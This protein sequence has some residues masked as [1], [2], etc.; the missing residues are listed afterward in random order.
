[1]KYTDLQFLKI[2]KA[3]LYG[4]QYREK[5]GENLGESHGERSGES[6]QPDED[7]PCKEVLSNIDYRRLFYLAEIHKVFPL[8]CETLVRSALDVNT[9]SFKK[10]CDEAVRQVYSQLSRTDDFLRL[11]QFLRG[12]GLEPLVVKGL[13][14]RQL[15]ALP[16]HRISMDEDVLIEKGE[17]NRYH[18]ALTEW[19]MELVHPGQDIEKEYEVSYRDPNSNMYIEVHKTLFPPGSEV[20]GDLNDFFENVL[21]HTIHCNIYKPTDKDQKEPVSVRC[22]NH[23]DH[24]LYMFFHTF[25]HFLHSGFGVR[26]ICDMALYGEVYFKEINWEDIWKKAEMIHGDE[27][28]RAII[29]IGIRCF[30]KKDALMRSRF[31]EWRL[32]SV[33]MEPLLTDIL[34]AGRN[35]RSSYSRI[36]SSSMTLQ[37]MADQRN[38]RRESGILKKSMQSVFLPLSTMKHRYPYLRKCPWLLP[39]AWGQRMMGYIKELHRTDRNYNSIQ[40]SIRQ[41]RK[42]IQ[43][44]EKYRIL[45]RDKGRR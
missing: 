29:A 17:F 36:H 44:M 16:C 8:V 31:K 25:K 20:Y 19:G 43:L 14:V 28:L 35:G 3:S 2:V 22:M 34:E 9:V 7:S 15:Y 27:L 33:E 40:D 24:F 39:A 32:D 42:R 37:A 11:Y 4:E 5:S 10:C 18:Q 26:Q 12:K 21:E 6:I 1:M 13:I 45:T 38:E 23:T 30:L 41:G